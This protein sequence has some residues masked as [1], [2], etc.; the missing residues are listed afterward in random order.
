MMRYDC[1]IILILFLLHTISLNHTF[2]F[3]FLFLLLCMMSS[4]FLFIFFISLACV[5]AIKEWPI[6]YRKSHLPLPDLLANSIYALVR[7]K[8][9]AKTVQERA[10]REYQSDTLDRLIRCR[11]NNTRCFRLR[12]P[13]PQVAFGKFC[14][15]AQKFEPL[16]A[17]ISQLRCSPPA[18]PFDATVATYWSSV[19]HKI[20][21]K[22]PSTE[23]AMSVSN[24]FLA[25]S[26][27]TLIE[28]PRISWRDLLNSP[29]PLISIL[30]GQQNTANTIDPLNPLYPLNPLFP[31]SPLN[32]FLH[33]KGSK[34]HSPYNSNGP[35]YPLN[36]ASPFS[37]F[38][39]QNPFNAL[40]PMLIIPPSDS[41]SPWNPAS[42]YF[43]LNP[44][45]PYNPHNEHSPMHPGFSLD[46]PPPASPFSPLNEN[47]LMS[48]HSPWYPLSPL[49][50][51]SL[52]PESDPNSPLNSHSPFHPLAALNPQN[53]LEDLPLTDFLNP[54]NLHDHPFNIINGEEVPRS[55]SDT[56]PAY[57]IPQQN[58]LLKSVTPPIGITEA[59]S[60]APPMAPNDLYRKP[61]RSIGRWFYQFKPKQ[62]TISIV[63]PCDPKS[64][65]FAGNAYSPYHPMHPSNPYSILN[66]LNTLPITDPRSPYNPRSSSYAGNPESP[67]NP[68]HPMNPFN[69]KSFI[70]TCRQS[71]SLHPL[72]PR[73]PF[74]LLNPRSPYNAMNPFSPYNPKHPLLAGLEDSHALNPALRTSPFHPS[75]SGSPYNPENYKKLNAQYPLNILNPT[76]KKITSEKDPEPL[77]GWYNGV[78]ED[79]SRVA[80]GPEPQGS[81]PKDQLIPY[82]AP[83]LPVNCPPA[84][85]APPA[86]QPPYFPGYYQWDPTW[87][88]PKYIRTS[89]IPSNDPIPADKWNQIWSQLWELKCKRESLL[90]NPRSPFGNDFAIVDMPQS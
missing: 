6:V 53:P 12:K 18:N 15:A 62:Q 16:R 14:W 40:C 2:T 17:G 80:P 51:L 49:A 22:T 23:L 38:N 25:Q 82:T 5:S 47:F 84:P 36:P 54:L 3:I 67:Y 68:E 71:G 20:K 26:E 89:N 34:T 55:L 21:P 81:D 27:G 63:N 88:A 42:P 32:P 58:S 46:G 8:F 60:F 69:P 39:P 43:P 44:H 72:N 57:I 75:H 65:F 77:L 50:Q 70:F 41:Q 52:L 9:P 59:N 48:R 66:P 87:P 74:Y 1:M 7:P 30:L 24:F 28:P 78:K 37:P 35:F 11:I 73:S 61:A 19:I 45:S 13:A 29:I 10:A 64:P 31:Y 85:P 83:K 76:Y 90:A 79:F 56:S 86:P 33:L 4:P